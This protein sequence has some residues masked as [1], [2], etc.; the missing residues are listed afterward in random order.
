M[1]IMY[2]YVLMCPLCSFILNSPCNVKAYSL[3][4]PQPTLPPLTSH[5][6][7][8]P[9][10]WCRAGLG[11]QRETKLEMRGCIGQDFEKRAG[12]RV[13]QRLE[14]EPH[15]AVRSSAAVL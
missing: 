9:V 2:K 10:V 6:C 7:L 5:S 1:C 8:Q 3:K 15:D 4:A 12:V 13:L 14:P 11:L